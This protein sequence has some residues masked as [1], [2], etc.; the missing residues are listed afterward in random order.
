MLD[1]TIDT[2]APRT[3]V[4]LRSIAAALLSREVREIAGRAGVN[5]FKGHFR[6]LDNSRH[7]KLGGPRSHFWSAAAD[8]TNF[9]VVPE[10]AE[11]NVAHT[12]VA[13]RYHGGTVR[14]VNAKALAIPARPEA[15]GRLPR[16]PEL[17][18]LFVIRRRA[19]GAAL[20]ARVG[21]ALQIYFWLV[22]SARHDP[23]PSVLPT[24][25]YLSHNVRTAVMSYLDRQI[26]R[27]MRGAIGG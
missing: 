8:A 12:G 17:P 14:P 18:E 23:D 25:E 4:I 13:L 2:S 5:T 15:Y 9:R 11:I 10:G 19:G 26:R 1:M 16:D 22:K 20:A 7:N 6:R 21:G 3:R 27:K 24:E